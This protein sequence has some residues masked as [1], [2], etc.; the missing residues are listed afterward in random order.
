M[1][2]ILMFEASNIASDRKDMAAP[3]LAQSKSLAVT[4][5]HL[6]KLG[7]W[8]FA[9]QIGL[10]TIFTLV[11]VPVIGLFDVYHAQVMVLMALIL[12]GEIAEGTSGLVE[13]PMVFNHPAVASRNIIITCFCVLMLVTSGAYFFGIL[14]AAAG[15]AMA[16]F[17]LAILRFRAAR[18]QLGLSICEPSYAKP[19]VASMMLTLVITG[20]GMLLTADNTGKLVAVIA[21]SAALY[22]VLLRIMGLSL[23]ITDSA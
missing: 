13:L 17:I 14:G 9:S 5:A 19:L 6:Q 11:A 12:L 16:M 10:T 1:P 3:F 21:A 23:R 8:I 2:Y 20:A 22:L 18:H 15:F 4:Q 7:L